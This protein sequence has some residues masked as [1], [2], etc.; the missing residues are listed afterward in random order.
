MEYVSLG[1]TGVMVSRLALGLGFRAVTSRE[2]AIRIINHAVDSGINFVDCSNFYGLVGGA[3]LSEEIL[4]PFLKTRRDDL[5]ITS[6]VFG[7]IGS[8]PNDYG[9]SRYHIMREAEASLRRLGTDHI[10]VYL[11]HGYDDE[12]PLD[13]TLRALDDLVSQGKVLYVGCCNFAAWQVCK[14]LWTADCLN[15]TPIVCVQHPYSLLNR[16]IETDLF[17]LVRDH[18]L[19][20]MAFS[21]LG[22]GLLGGDYSIGAPP[23]P[24]TLWRSK[25]RARYE[26]SMSGSTGVVLDE[27]LRVGEGRDKTA[28]QVALNWVMNKDAVTVAICGCDNVEQLDDNLGAVGWSLS[29]DE[30]AVLDSVSR[31]T[32]IGFVNL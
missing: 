26:I 25:D 12:T 17:G 16:A 4:R 32:N 28:A 22:A 30:M 13:E 15:T 29:D 24:G 31:G 19:G 2:D 10:D 18:G 9:S 1:K 20:L 7:K 21:P 14:A 27:L 23:P 5:V 11:L 6:K 3:I 8:G